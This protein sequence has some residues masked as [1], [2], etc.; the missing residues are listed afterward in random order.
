LGCEA[1][2]RNCMSIGSRVKASP[3]SSHPTLISA[4]HRQHAGS[5]MTRTFILHTPLDPEQLKFVQMHGREALSEVFEF[6]L[7]CVS[8]TDEIDVTDL[9]GQSVTVEVSPRTAVHAI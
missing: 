4:A 2:H 3:F 5:L 8:P 7:Q 6:D 1:K 9:L